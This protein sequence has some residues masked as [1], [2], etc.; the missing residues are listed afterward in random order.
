MQAF[1]DGLLN[2]GY[3]KV[4]CIGSIAGRVGGVISGPN[5]VASKGGVHAFVKW[6]A[7]D[8]ADEGVYVNAI[9]PGPVWSGMTRGEN[10]TPDM[11][12]LG[13]IG[14]PEDIAEAVVFLASPASNWITG[15]VLDVNG[16][17]LMD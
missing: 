10:Y 8:A 1:Y 16:G 6:A 15:T 14:E 17:M 13:R 9:A 4:V 5:Y 12:P 2:D 3:G 7:K 11:A